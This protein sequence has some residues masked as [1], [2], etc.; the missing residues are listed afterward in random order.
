MSRGADGGEGGTDVANA[1]TGPCSSVGI[2][3]EMTDRR[4]VLMVLSGRNRMVS[5]IRVPLG[6]QPVGHPELATCHGCLIRL[7][8][9][10]E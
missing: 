1:R 7:N 4:R 8:V 3:G 9:S 10:S 2:A 5:V 6:E